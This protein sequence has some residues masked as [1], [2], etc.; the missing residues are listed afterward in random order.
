[1]RYVTHAVEMHVLCALEAVQHACVH[2]LYTYTV[3]MVVQLCIHACLQGKLARG[4]RC[5]MYIC[6]MQELRIHVQL[7]YLPQVQ[8]TA[9]DRR[10]AQTYVHTYT[11]ECL[12]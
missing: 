1:M 9:F 5:L 11:F 2:M 12:P 8:I 10:C 4:S 6:F 7:V 3:T